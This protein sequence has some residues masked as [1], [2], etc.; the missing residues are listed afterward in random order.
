MYDLIIIGM[1]PA[2]M[3]AAIY[4]KRAGLNVLC[5]EKAMIGGYLNYIDRI[6]NYV[7]LYGISGPDFAFK[8]YETI[9]DLGIRV[10]TQEVVSIVD[11]SPKKVITSTGEFLAKK[12]IIA[13]GRNPRK[14]G[15]SGEEE[16]RGHGIS[17]CALCDGAFYRNKNV[18]VV[19]GGDSALQEALYLSAI[20]N[21]VY[22]I[23]RKEQF[24]VSGYNAEKVKGCKNIIP[25][26]SSSVQ[27]FQE[28]D[29]VL[30]GILL[31]TGQEIKVSGLFVYI[32]FEPATSFVSALGITNENGYILVDSKC[33]TKLSGIYAIGDIIQKDIYQIS[34]GVGEGAIAASDVIEKL[35]TLL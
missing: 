3:S 27:S 8:L 1:G 34:V 6:D 11:G 18:A 15:I 33:E 30:D 7:G 31:D 16:L 23:H 25:V 29:G 20:C 5:I 14:L 17:H 24:S 13:T 22:L 32:G 10:E 9:Q 35:S 26:F 28:K 2:G 19:G 4:A 21:R 12:I